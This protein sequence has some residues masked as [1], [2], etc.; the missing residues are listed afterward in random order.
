MI[1]FRYSLLMLF[2]FLAACSG[3]SELNNTPQILNFTHTFFLNKRPLKVVIFDTPAEREKG[4]MWVK[5]LPANHGALFVF[6]KETEV[7]FWMKNTL[8][9]LDML[10]FDENYQ[11]IKS[12][13]NALPCNNK[14][15]IYTAYPVRYVLETNS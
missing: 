14:C 11:L 8:I 3:Q 6:D 2:L 1:I 7:S 13:K 12:I 10:F 4:L 5:N 15:P 9:S